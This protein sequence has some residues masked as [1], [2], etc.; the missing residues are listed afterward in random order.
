MHHLA[1]MALRHEL[2]GG[3]VP[4][5]VRGVLD[6]VIRRTLGAAGTFDDQGWLRVGLC[7]HQPSIGEAY[8]STGSLYLCSTAF[9]PL[10]LPADDPFWTDPDAPSTGQRTWSGVNMP[11]DHALAPS[12]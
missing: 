12:L 1:Y 2:P 7:G 8:I 10:G 6:S 3:V 5:Q 4:A 9:L 11:A